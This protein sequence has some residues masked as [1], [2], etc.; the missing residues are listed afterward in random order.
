MEVYMDD[1]TVYGGSFEKCF[2]NLVTVLQR[3]I[4]ELGAE[5]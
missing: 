2:I 1:I 4:E 3:C 5:L